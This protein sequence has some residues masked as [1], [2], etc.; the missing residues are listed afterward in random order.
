MQIEVLD[1]VHRTPLTG[2]PGTAKMLFFLQKTY[3]W[4]RMD[5][6]VK[7]YLR[8]C[9]ECQRTKPFNDTYNGLLNPLSV[10]DPPI[11]WRHI[12]M[13]FITQLPSTKQGHNTIAVQ[14]CRL[15]KRRIFIALRAG[16]N[17]LSTKETAMLIFR[18]AQR[19]G[20]GMIDSFVSDRG[21]QW[22]CEF[23][24]HLCHLWGI[25]QQMS[26]AFHL[27]WPRSGPV[28]K[29]QDQTEFLWFGPVRSGKKSDRTGL[30]QKD[31]TVRR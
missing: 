25:C 19:L 18:T 12:S 28:P 13:D 31:C 7:Q 30:Y 20:A 26:T 9:H 24:D 1:A 29:F 3:Y 23:W 22:D 2:H 27:D 6:S 21:S 16:N 5:Q 11:S 14:V 10:P 4:P 17:G 8:N 15:T